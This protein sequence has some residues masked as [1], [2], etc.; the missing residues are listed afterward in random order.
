MARRPLCLCG[1]SAVRH[2]T[3]RGACTESVPTFVGG[4][5]IAHE[6]CGCAC[7]DPQDATEPARI[8]AGAYTGPM[9]GDVT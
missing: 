8:P 9:T 1:H 6:P 4:R 5:L 3:W 7:Y 2:I